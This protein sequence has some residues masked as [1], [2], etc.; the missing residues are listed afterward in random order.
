[1]PILL[2]ALVFGGAGVVGSLVLMANMQRQRRVARRL[3][4]AQTGRS[5]R[6]APQTTRAEGPLLLYAIATLGGAVARSGI[7][8]ANTIEELEQTLVSSGLRGRQGVGLFIG[9]KLLLLVVLPTLA[10]LL[11]PG[12]ELS[13]SSVRTA[14]V[15][16]ALVGL[17]LPDTIVKRNRKK[18]LQRL[19]AGVSDALDMLVICAQAGLGLETAMQRVAIEIRLARPEIA[20]EL[21]TTLKEMRI[22]VDSQRAIA[23]LGTRT[24]LAT[25]RRVSATLVQTLQYGTPLTDALRVLSAE[26]R[27]DVLTKFE[28]RAARLPVLLTMP[29]IMFIFPCIFIVMAG[30]AGMKL[31]VA[32]TH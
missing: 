9:S 22:A 12:F 7:L 31:A 30:P 21:E 10:L 1:M 29:M 32:F 18:Y 24:G 14:A 13:S 26:M 11:L 2:A 6:G 17:L 19:D 28:A 3:R 5:A 27:Q 8:S 15:G 4:G 25:L 20:G 23:A 16:A